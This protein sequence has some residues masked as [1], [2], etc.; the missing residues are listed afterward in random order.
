M[1]GDLRSPCLQP[2]GLDRCELLQ[3]SRAAGAKERFQ[4]PSAVPDL[5]QQSPVEIKSQHELV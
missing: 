4:L 2:V 1:P 3:L 5:S